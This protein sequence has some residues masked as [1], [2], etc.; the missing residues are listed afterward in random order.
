[1]CFD[2]AGTKPA[3]GSDLIGGYSR[4]RGVKTRPIELRPESRRIWRRRPESGRD[5][6]LRA[7]GNSIG[8]RLHLPDPGVALR[9]VPAAA[10]DHVVVAVV[11]PRG[12]A[13][14]MGDER[15]HQRDV[16]D[17]HHHV[18]GSRDQERHPDD[19]LREQGA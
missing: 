8:G 16:D 14:V 19:R 6:G 18:D 3:G 10:G 2:W 12:R 15:E 11:V 1:M 9:V 17:R 13:L 4:L 5:Q 7:R